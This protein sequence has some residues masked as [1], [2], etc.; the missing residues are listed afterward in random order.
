MS[1]QSSPSLAALLPAQGCVVLRGGRLTAAWNC[2]WAQS[3]VPPPGTRAGA[4]KASLVSAGLGI[5]PPSLRPA[6]CCSPQHHWR[7]THPSGFNPQTGLRGGQEKQPSPP[8]LK[9][10]KSAPTPF[11]AASP[12]RAQRTPR[13]GA[14]RYV[15]PKRCPGQCDTRRDGAP[16][17]VPGVGSC[18]SACMQQKPLRG[19]RGSVRVQRA[20]VRQCQP[21]VPV[22]TPDMSEARRGQRGLEA[23][24]PAGIVSSAVPAALGRDSYRGWSSAETPPGQWQGVLAASARPPR[25]D[26]TNTGLCLVT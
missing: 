20:E 26:I 16:S 24:A 1:S 12:G 18:G 13:P 11:R 4:V 5:L 8:R 19:D 3:A 25:S 2:P 22:H 10:G 9:C 15:P 6:R 23:P 7:G 21:A 17:T 14:H